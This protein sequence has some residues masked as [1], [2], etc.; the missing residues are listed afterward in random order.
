MVLLPVVL[1]RISWDH[2]FQLITE[3]EGRFYFKIRV[4][5]F[6]LINNWDTLKLVKF[7]TDYFFLPKSI[8]FVGFTHVVVG[9]NSRSLK[10]DKYLWYRGNVIRASLILFFYYM[11]DIF[12]HK[13]GYQFHLF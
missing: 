11:N 13:L 7:A 12:L 6:S 4:F 5:T 2:L 9:L 1:S 10:Q 8:L 3:P